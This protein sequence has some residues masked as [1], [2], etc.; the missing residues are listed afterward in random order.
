MMLWLSHFF[1]REP[2]AM[3]Q[4]E[5][6]LATLDSMWVD[7]PGYV[8]REPG[9]RRMKFAFAN[10]GVSLGLQSVSA[11]TDHVGRLNAFFAAYRSG[12]AHD[13]DAITQ[14]MRCTSHRPGDFIQAATQDDAA[15][16]RTRGAEGCPRVGRQTQRPL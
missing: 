13:M 9:L 15:R 11:E 3:I 2:W 14:V 16:A 5:R 6:A 12:D 8:C 4:R 1:L 10:Y 7:P